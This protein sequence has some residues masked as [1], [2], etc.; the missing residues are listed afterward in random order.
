MLNSHPLGK[1]NNFGIGQS[2]N[3]HSRDTLVVLKALLEIEKKGISSFC[4]Y[5]NI[6]ENHLIKNMIIICFFH[7][8]GKLTPEFQN[9]MVNANSYYLHNK[10][11]KPP[12]G[13]HVPHPFFLFK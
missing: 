5:W 7:D 11:G 1:T 12:S 3:G 4:H 8:I 13:R 6:N 2:L 9:M 10:K